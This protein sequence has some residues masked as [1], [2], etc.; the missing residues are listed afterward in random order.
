MPQ[1][2]ADCLVEGSHV[3]TMNERREVILDG[4]VAVRGT[5][6]VAVGKAS[7]L[8]DQDEDARRKAM[9]RVRAAQL[10]MKLSD[11]E[12]QWD[13]KK[14]TLYFTAEKRVDFR[15]LVRELASRFTLTACP[16]S[17]VS[18]TFVIQRSWGPFCFCTSRT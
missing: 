6:I 7:E 2:P 18:F 12:W 9:E 15:A 13:R 5:E 17:N 3:V 8:R 16:P 11:A 1:E 14:L 10:A 4:A